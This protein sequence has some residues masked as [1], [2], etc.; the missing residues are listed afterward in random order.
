ML[1]TERLIF[2]PTASAPTV[3]PLNTGTLVEMAV[4]ESCW[5]ARAD[6]G[7]HVEFMLLPLTCSCVALST[8]H[9]VFP[10]TER[11][12]GIDTRADVWIVNRL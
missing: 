5:V 10:V 3:A 4:S 1:A 11:V 9:V 8:P 6:C 7:A 2:E 12:P